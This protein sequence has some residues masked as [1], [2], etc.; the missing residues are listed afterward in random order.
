[1]DVGELN[2]RLS[3]T[4]TVPNHLFHGDWTP[5]E[6]GLINSAI[7]LSENVDPLFNTWIFRKTASNFSV[8]RKTWESGSLSAGSVEG[9]VH[10]ITDYLNPTPYKSKSD[11]KPSDSS[12]V[13]TFNQV[14]SVLKES[15]GFKNSGRIGEIVTYVNRDF[16]YAALHLRKPDNPPHCS[17]R[18]LADNPICNE[19]IYLIGRELTN[20]QDQDFVFPSGVSREEAQNR[21]LEMAEKMGLSQENR[22]SGP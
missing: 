20:Y 2:L 4:E 5:E 22:P 13:Q 1:M 3:N 10:E 17:F 9:L 15:V 11:N 16:G 7:D 8:S 19:F 6:K 12:L 18:A 14:F 21:L